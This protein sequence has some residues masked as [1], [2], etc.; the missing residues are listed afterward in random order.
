[1]NIFE[2][3][4]QKEQDAEAHYRSLA[5]T[6]QSE[7]LEHIF[8]MLADAEVR[9]YN[10]VREMQST[11]PEVPTSNIVDEALKALRQARA[12]KSM[13]TVSDDAQTEAYEKARQIEDESIQFYNEQADKAE[14]EK[15]E[16]IF[17]QL[18]NQEK[19]H[20]VL[21]DNM[22]DFVSKPEQWIED[23]EFTHILDKYRGTDYY[24]DMP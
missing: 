23:A 1:M 16:R 4:M 18:A 8:T 20:Y 24:P 5:Q 21:V 22:A 7:G 15:A 11:T 12:S 17:R 3:A 13:A 9:H 10:V 6:S 14:D 2:F 19:M